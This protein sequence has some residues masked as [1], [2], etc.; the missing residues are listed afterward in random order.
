M[1]IPSPQHMTIPINTVFHSHVIYCF[2]QINIKS[3]DPC[4][5]LQT[6]LSPCI[7]VLRNSA[8]V[9]PPCFTSI[10][11]CWPYITLLTI[12]LFYQWMVRWIME[13]VIVEISTVKMVLSIL[14]KTNLLSYNVCPVYLHQ[15]CVQNIIFLHFNAKF[16]F[17]HLK[18]CHQILLHF[19]VCMIVFQ[20]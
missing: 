17:A 19:I 8:F 4:A 5:A 3:L 13:M 12:V 6:L 1:T 14:R 16:S 15:R 2:I 9:Q 10:Q 7:S 18:L 20:L 11:Y